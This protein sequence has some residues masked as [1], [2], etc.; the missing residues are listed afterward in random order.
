ME[1]FITRADKLVKKLKNLEINE[2]LYNEDNFKNAIVNS[3]LN[4]LTS[5]TNDSLICANRYKNDNKEYIRITLQIKSQNNAKVKNVELIVKTIKEF[6][7]HFIS[8]DKIKVYQE[9]NIIYLD[10]YKLDELN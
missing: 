4:N 2:T 9:D 1:N 10:F 5:Q 8:I 3:G 7:C 6:E